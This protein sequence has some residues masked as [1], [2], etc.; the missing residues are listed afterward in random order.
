M[1]VRRAFSPNDDSM[2]FQ[3]IGFIR[4]VKKRGVWVRLNF[5]YI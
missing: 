5:L 1:G 4:N 3:G 2:P